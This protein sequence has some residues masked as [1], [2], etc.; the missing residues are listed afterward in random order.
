MSMTE[1]NIE[2]CHL[3]ALFSQIASSAAIDLIAADSSLITVNVL[4]TGFTD[5]LA[6]NIQDAES[7][8]W[9]FIEQREMQ[10]ARGEVIFNRYEGTV[11]FD[12][13]EVIIPIL[14]G[15]EM[16]EFC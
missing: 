4:D 7:L 15:E 2:K 10:T 16:S 13:Q 3:V 6:R 1:K 8:G 11:M 9:S 12:G 14:G 5:W